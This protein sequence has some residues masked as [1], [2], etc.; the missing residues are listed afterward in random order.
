MP[1]ARQ[2]ASEKTVLAVERERQAIEMRLAGATYAFIGE[3]LGIT[4][5][6]AFRAVMR[7]LASIRGKTAEDAAKLREI[8]DERLSR[9]LRAIDPQVRQG[10]LGAVDRALRIS[11]QRSRMWGLDEPVKTDITSGGKSFT[12]VVRELAE[13]ERIASGASAG[14]AVQG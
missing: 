12:D 10:H 7:G 4:T 11:Q 5:S 1:F 13:L 8:E 6:G 9:M 2:Q 14:S 3:T